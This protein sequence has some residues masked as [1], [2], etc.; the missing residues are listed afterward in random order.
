MNIYTKLILVILAIIVVGT[1][2]VEPEMYV[3][4]VVVGHEGFG[5]TK[6][7]A[8][9][10]KED[11]ANVDNQKPVDVIS[12]LPG[13]KEPGCISNGLSTDTGAVCLTADVVQL[14]KTRGGNYA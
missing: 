6:G 11:T 4:T 12:T 3:S 10:H 14:L 9:V 2:F 1:L 5:S 8:S 13:S 7:P